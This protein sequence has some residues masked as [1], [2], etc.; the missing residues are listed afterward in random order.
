MDH[1]LLGVAALKGH[2]KG[3]VR[4]KTDQACRAERIGHPY[5]LFR[6]VCP[7]QTGNLSNPGVIIPTNARTKGRTVLTRSLNHQRKVSVGVLALALLVSTIAWPARGADEKPPENKD[8]PKILLAAPLGISP[9]VPAK[10][11]FRG[12]KLE[13]LTDIR[14]GDAKLSAKIVNKGAAAPPNGQ[15]APRSGDTQV[16]VEISLP[17][18]TPAGTIVVV[19]QNAAGESQPYA[20]LV[21]GAVPPVPEVEPND[22]F[23]QA[24]PA[25]IG[26]VIEGS[27]HQNQNVDV[28]RVDSRA[29]Q[30][31]LI[32]VFA[33]RHGSVLDSVLTVY[34]AKRRLL[35]T[36]DDQSGTA[37]SRLEWTCPAEGPYYVVLQD[38]HDQG[39]PAHPYRLSITARE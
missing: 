14:F 22:G 2:N 37:D 10:L 9:G 1:A 7:E 3:A 36:N 25:T 33:A 12:L 38:A 30:K 18:E 35:A 4:K 24:Q 34:D 29:G 11:T 21:N 16:E 15:E 6:W 13:A 19:A 8:L 5:A 32:E 26:T 17:A 28:F 27:V 39:G 20:L 31:L 23:T